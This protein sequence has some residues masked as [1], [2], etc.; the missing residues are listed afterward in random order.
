MNKSLDRIWHAGSDAI[1]RPRTSRHCRMS[2][3]N[4]SVQPS[5][6]PPLEQKE[7]LFYRDK[8]RTARYLALADAEGFDEICF[9]VEA[10]GMR[11]L[12]KEGAL[13]QYME[14]I[15][16]LA[17]HSTVLAE[18]PATFP[19][20]FTRFAALYTTLRKA[21]NDSMHTGSYARHATSSAIELCIG[22]EEALMA[23][24]SSGRVA[25]HM[26]K[27]PVILEPWHPVAHARQLM[28]MHSFSFLPVYIDSWKLVS[29]LA[30][31]KYLHQHPDRRKLVAE[32][33]DQAYGKGLGLV[34][35]TVVDPNDFVT[36]LLSSEQHTYA[37]TLWLVG[38]AP[39][40]LAGVLSP[41]E[42]M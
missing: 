28:L 4:A 39:G 18:M 12:G 29:E 24:D 36:D 20:L 9:A 26:V 1:T 27:A 21:R 10:L 15:G 38:D 33:I 6:A 35:A 41:H 8:L 13:N 22:L 5:P 14:A 16:N 7:R 42:L 32:T 23:T 34:E 40:R 31:A 25:D 2:K 19:T 37:P 30:M 11:L 17:Q 3:Q